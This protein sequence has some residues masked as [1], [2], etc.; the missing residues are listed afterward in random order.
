MMLMRQKLDP[1]SKRP[2]GDAVQLAPI[3]FSGA[4][5]SLISVTRDRVFF[6]TSE[7]RSNVWMTNID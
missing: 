1:D 4:G 2:S 3:P 5:V 7:V 6:N